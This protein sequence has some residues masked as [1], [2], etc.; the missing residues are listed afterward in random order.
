MRHDFA[1]QRCIEVR[2]DLYLPFEDAKFQFTL[3][4]A[5]PGKPRDGFT[6]ARNYHV[7]A[8]RRLLDE[9]GKL[10]LR[11]VNIDDGYWKLLSLICLV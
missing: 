6:A 5:E 2:R 11:I 1:G 7:I 8:G 4:G 3:G 10:G 9:L